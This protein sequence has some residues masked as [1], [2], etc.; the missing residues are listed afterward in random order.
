MALQSDGKLLIAGGFDSDSVGGL[1]KFGVVRLTATGQLDTSFDG[2]GKVI[3]PFLGYDFAKD[4]AIQSDGKIVVVGGTKRADASYAPVVA[5]YNV[6]GSL[7]SNFSGDGKL[8]SDIS[9]YG[10]AGV[11][12]DGDG[13]I[14]TT[15][16]TH[17]MRYLSQ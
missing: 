5:R 16:Q 2:D 4:L 14:V 7:D 1:S 15:H 3:T 11:V 10:H 6:N 13:K 9:I 17:G 12:L 8:Q